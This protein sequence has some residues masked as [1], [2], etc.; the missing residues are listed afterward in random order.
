MFCPR[1]IER[2]S[3]GMIAEWIDTQCSGIPRT[4]SLV[5]SL[6]FSLE[7]ITKPSNCSGA[8]AIVV[9]CSVFCFLV[10]EPSLVM[11]DGMGF[12]F[13]VGDHQ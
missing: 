7:W 9:D 6:H 11:L 1:D 8:D 3:P 10:V 12:C 13:V 5:K 2:E 4:F